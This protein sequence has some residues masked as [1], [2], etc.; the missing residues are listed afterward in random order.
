MTNTFN[1]QLTTNDP[2]SAS[3]VAATNVDGI[4]PSSSYSMTASFVLNGGSS[5]GINGMAYITASTSWTVPSGITKVHAYVVGGGGGCN[6][7][8][9]GYGGAGG[10]YT[11]DVV[12]VTPGSI[13]PI[14]VG[15][16]GINPGGGGTGTAGSASY[17]LYLTASGGG[18]ENGIGG[19]GYSGSINVSGQ[20]VNYNNAGGMPGCSPLIPALPQIF[21]GVTSGQANN[22]AILPGRGGDGTGTVNTN[23]YAG[24]VLLYY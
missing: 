2:I 10:G 22:V 1:A 3:Y 5:G 6:P 13:I 19:K 9:S 17:F 23:G 15:V 8:H 14:T 24:M 16:G 20:N 18:G 21:P 7:N 12:P 11:E 4:I